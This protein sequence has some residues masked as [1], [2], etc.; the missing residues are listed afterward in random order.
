MRCS[1]IFSAHIRFFFVVLL[2]F[3]ATESAFSQSISNSGRERLPKE[4]EPYSV[5][6]DC[7][8]AEHLCEWECLD[9]DNYEDC[10]S[11]CKCDRAFC[12]FSANGCF[13]PR[14]EA[15]VLTC[16]MWTLGVKICLVLES[17]ESPKKAKEAPLFDL[18]FGAKNAR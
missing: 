12:E 6:Y 5:P 16:Q 14:T 3:T 8:D 15:E 2:L 9:E 1:S 7:Y 17:L 13:I 4:S 18:R 10:L 11:Q